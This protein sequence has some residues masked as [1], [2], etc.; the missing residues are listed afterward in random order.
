MNQ[1]PLIQSA[2][3]AVI[4]AFLTYVPAYSQTASN[5]H[6][7][8]RFV[9]SR[10]ELPARALQVHRPLK[11]VL[12]G[13]EVHRYNLSLRD[14]QFAALRIDQ[15]DGNLT[16]T[17]FDPD[18]ELI[19]IVDQNRGGMGEVATIFATKTG[20]YSI[21]I[22]MY[23]WDKPDTNYAIEWTRREAARRDV[24]GRADQ[25]FRSWYE[26][27]HP[28]AALMVTTDGILAYSSAIGVE[29]TARRRPIS[30]QTSFD[31][32]S[33]SKQFTAY[34]IALLIDRG[35]LRADDDVRAYI[36]EI[37]DYG[38]KIRIQDLLQHTSG[39]RD[40]DGLFALMGRNIEDGISL[41]DIVAMASRQ[42]ALNFPPGSE[43][44][45]SNTNYSLLAAIIER[46]SG[47]KFDVWTRENI[48]NPLD[49]R[50]CGFARTSP[51]T[52][53]RQVAS[54]KARFP[55][56]V[57][58][59]TR[60]MVSM[61]SSS[62]ACS[63]HDLSLW[64]ANYRTGQLGGASV[65][66]L[67]TRG[68]EGASGLGS[69][70]VFGNWHTSRDGHAF[71]G[72]LGLAAGFR[73]AIRAFPNDKV[74]VIYLANDGNDATYERVRTI[75]NLFLGI[76]EKKVEVP[77]DANYTPAVT[78]PLSNTQIEQFA[79]LYRSADL[80]TDFEIVRRGDGIAVSHPVA[81]VL[82]L[83]LSSNDVFTSEKWV[84][85]KLTFTRNATGN[86]VGFRIDS[87]DFRGL[88]FDRAQLA[89][90]K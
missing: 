60:R 49:L 87:E 52:S 74:E 31:I 70:Y 86:V 25:L 32:A 11:A 41:D 61:G 3:G 57:P 45:Y 36:P 51:A 37:P 2:L 46:V 50:A 34:G 73:S 63:A 84:I 39:L 33:L 80:Q 28:G 54:Y 7:T 8:S 77:I 23:E 6:P 1:R 83:Q 59:S 38:T 53:V 42:L 17:V 9:L 14:G 66:K 48:F 16:A 81:G 68:F 30:I 5:P 88:Q 55:N 90:N 71:I 43:Q 26:P 27:G 44:E 89:T 79:G 13:P 4:L 18:G 64:L 24:R 67:V 15:L 12:K 40:W 82:E 78:T 47:Q 85:P 29:N 19:A 72:H 69:D 22:A 58:A 20:T 10:T 75:E 76:P 62:L 65:Q 21:Q 35:K 56:P